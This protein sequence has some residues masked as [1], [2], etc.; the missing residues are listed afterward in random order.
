MGFVYVGERFVVFTSPNAAKIALLE[1]NP[2]VA[3]T[4]DTESQPPNVLLVRGDAQLSKVD[5]VPDQFVEASRK[6]IPP[7]DF[8]AWEDGVRALY[9]EMVRIDITPRWA[10]VLDFETRIPSAVG[11]LVRQRQ[12]E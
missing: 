7:E 9:T 12:A 10:K 2:K 3:L 4:I 11:E 8:E 5:G 1:A 6:L